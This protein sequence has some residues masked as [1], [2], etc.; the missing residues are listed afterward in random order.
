MTD[1]TVRHTEP[2]DYRALHAIFTHPKVV[3]G[4]MQLPHPS[5]ESWRKRLETPSPDFYSL[6]A[7]ADEEVVG[8]IGLSVLTRPRRRHVGTL[9]MAV[10][11]DWQGRGVGS[12][13]MT[14]ALELADGWLQLTR[15]ELTVFT[16]NAPAVALYEKF[17]FVLEGTHKGYAFRDGAYVDTYTMARL[18]PEPS[19]SK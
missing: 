3:W 2:S 5:V 10:R 11:D 13:L 12:A 1:L 15:V 16:D 4:T 17:G 18:R 8:N 9:G 6:V 14:A 7:C 19:F